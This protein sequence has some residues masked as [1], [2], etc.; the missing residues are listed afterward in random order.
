MSLRAE[1]C[2]EGAMKRTTILLAEDHAMVREGLRKVLDL[3]ADFEV[4]GEANDG[5]QAV[6]LA[7]KLDPVVLLMDLGM[8][9]LN[10]WEATS[11]VLQAKPGIRVVILSAHGE[12][13][14]VKRAMDAGVAGF[15]LKQNGLR[16]LCLAIRTVVT[17]R[18]FFVPDVMSRMERGES[19]FGRDGVKGQMG[20]VELS[21]R[22]REVLQLIAEGKANKQ[23]AAELGIGIKTVEKHRG[24][25]M[26]KLGIHETAGLTRYAIGAGIIEVGMPSFVE[27]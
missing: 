3:E 12:N 18:S 2:G 17:G 14:Y 11:K 19:V 10:G 27:S 26:E 9:L 20:K 15:V 23:T 6:Q 4:I 5:R 1:G 16:D 22:E 8:P 7:K 24:R 13:V 21:G 25:I